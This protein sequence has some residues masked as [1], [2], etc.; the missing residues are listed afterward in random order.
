MEAVGS[1]TSGIPAP[2]K[3]ERPPQTRKG[4]H[5]AKAPCTA[6]ATS[7]PESKNE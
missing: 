1:P 6:G 2:K 5:E 7:I 3:G 4:C